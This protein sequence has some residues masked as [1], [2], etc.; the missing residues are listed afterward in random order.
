M[1]RIIYLIL[2][3]IL[4]IS[5]CSLNQEGSGYLTIKTPEIIAPPVK[6]VINDDVTIDPVT[7]PSF[8]RY[9]L[10]IETKD[11]RR[12]KTEYLKTNEE[13]AIDVPAGIPLNFFLGVYIAIDESSFTEKFNTFVLSDSKENI[14][15]ING[16]TKLIEFNLDLTKSTKVKSYYGSLFTYTLPTNLYSVL[17]VAVDPI[18]AYFTILPLSPKELPKKT[19]VVKYQDGKLSGLGFS[20]G[21]LDNQITKIV[22]VNNDV[23][24]Y[25]YWL[26]AGNNIYRVEQMNTDLIS[27]ALVNP[28]RQISGISSYSEYLVRARK[29]ISLY[30]QKQGSEPHDRYYYFINYGN[31]FLGFNNG[32]NQDPSPTWSNIKN[33]TFDFTLSKVRQYSLL[34]DMKQDNIETTNTFVLTKMGTFYADEQ[35]LAAFSNGDYLKGINEFKKIIFIKE[36]K[37]NNPIL[38]TSVIPTQNRIYFGTRKGLYYID[39]NNSYWKD[40]VNAKRGDKM[41]LLDQKAFI[42]LDDLNNELVE[43][44]FLLNI[45]GDFEILVACTPKRI[46]F[47]NMNNGKKDY[48]TL[49]DGLLF[50][51]IGKLLNIVSGNEVDFINHTIAPVVRIFYKNNIIWIA[52]RFGLSSISISELN[53]N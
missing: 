15:L 7:K 14:V 41:I 46:L 2:A 19:T 43:N 23:N 51:P 36:E 42:K 48:L 20:M 24:D 31:G 18:N 9:V 10:L 49:R 1:K 32:L 39:R 21:D 53:I 8:L 26:I 52:T 37:D 5:S 17:N 47:Y 44:M 33:I 45:D 25:N 27:N 30:F 29:I 40:F 50:V 22:R 13:K 34:I 6:S 38:I 4:I 11:G 12:I 16:E 35:G 28:A 3:L